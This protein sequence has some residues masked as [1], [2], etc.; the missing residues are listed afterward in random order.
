MAPFE[1]IVSDVRKNRGFEISRSVTSAGIDNL[2][3]MALAWSPEKKHSDPERYIRTN[4]TIVRKNPVT[5]FMPKMVLALSV[6]L[7]DDRPTIESTRT[8]HLFITS[9]FCYD[10]T[11]GI[12][13][14][15]HASSRSR[16]RLSTVD[17]RMIV[18]VSTGPNKKPSVWAS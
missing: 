8:H 18:Q 11:F 13:S 3:K 12:G 17:T 4:I 15:I 2:L 10:L 14:I 7:Y 5:L 1:S 9:L 16:L 6:F